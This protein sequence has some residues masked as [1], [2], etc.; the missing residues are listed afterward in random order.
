MPTRATEILKEI[1]AGNRSQVAELVAICYPELR[2]IADR[3]LS[4]E[5]D[6]RRTSP[7][8]VVHETFLRVIDQ[9]EIS[10]EDR[11]H[12][13]AINAK[14]MRQYLVDLARRESRQRRGGGMARYSLHALLDEDFA[15]TSQERDEQVLLCSELLEGLSA[16]DEKL[17]RIVEMRFFGGMTLDE[18]AEELGISISMVSKHWASAKAWLRREIQRHDD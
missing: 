8:E 12:F 13:M 4:G 14:L 10:F 2:A 11:A 6:R 5:R 7:T 16:V 17:A 18:V 3:T 9:T 1:S 15:K